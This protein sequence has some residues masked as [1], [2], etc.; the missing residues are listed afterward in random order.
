ML[1]YDPVATLQHYP[2]DMRRFGVNTFGQNLYRIVFAPSRRYLVCGDWDDSGVPRAQWVRKYKQLGDIWIME[3]WRPAEDW[4][5][6]EEWDR[7]FVSTL[8]PY[9]SRGEYDFCH[10]FELSGPED[11]NLDKLIAL[12][13]HGRT[14][15]FQDTLAWHRDD[16]AREKLA[17]Q[18]KVE[19]IIR[20]RL[21]AFGGRAIS[22]MG[23]N[24]VGHGRSFKTVKDLRSAQ[25]CGLPT[26][27]GMRQQVLPQSAA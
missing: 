16:H 7:N 15:R 19:D 21:P 11:A 23:G 17:M 24:A 6:P 25:E 22:G 9:P 13:A 10:G 3:R 8:G 26:R 20:N 2:I 5:T 4:G 18:K 14:I 1:T 12:I 27:P